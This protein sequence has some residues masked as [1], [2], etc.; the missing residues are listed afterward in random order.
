MS[1]GVRDSSSPI[2]LP[3]PLSTLL[4]LAFRVCAF[5]TSTCLSI[6]DLS[7]T[8]LGGIAN[9]YILSASVSYSLLF[10]QTNTPPT[11]ARGLNLMASSDPSGGDLCWEDPKATYISYMR[12]ISE[13]NKPRRVEAG[14]HVCHLYSI[15]CLLT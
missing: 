14:S 5:I 15:C 1:F 12:E 6:L 11:T 8:C 7:C 10:K 4:I 9:L 2:K 13:F 3:Q